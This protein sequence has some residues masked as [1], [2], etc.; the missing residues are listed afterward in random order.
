MRQRRRHAHDQPGLLHRLD[1]SQEAHGVLGRPTQGMEDLAGVDDLLQP[2][3]AIRRAADRLQQVEQLPLVAC[4]VVQR[5]AERRMA[6]GAVL[7][8]RRDIGRHE[9]ER[10]L[11]S[12]RFSARLKC[13]RPTNRQRLSRFLRN[14]CND[15]PLAESSVCSASCK[16]RQD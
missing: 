4:V 10:E 14:S 13:T 11:R 12:R 16:S 8:E 2:I 1:V 6:Q 7:G 15:P 5:L 3:E 9:G